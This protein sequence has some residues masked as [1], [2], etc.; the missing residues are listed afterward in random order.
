MV[1]RL[2]RRLAW[3]AA[4]LAAIPAAGGEPAKPAYDPTHDYEV[5]EIEGWRVLVNRKLVRDE[6]L[7]RETLAL[8]AHQLYQIPRKVPA[9]A[10]AKLRKI[11]VWV[12]A[13]EPHHPCMA[14][15]PSADWLREHGMNPEK[16]GCIEVANAKSF[17]DWT[18]QQPW[19]VFHELAHAYHDRFLGGFG[20]REL[21][22]VF[23]RATAARRYERVLHWRGNF[24]RAYAARN[25]MEHFAESSEAFFG[26]NDF[27][28]FVA[29]ELE[30]HDPETFRLLEKLWGR[31]PSPPGDD[32]TKGS[33]GRGASPAP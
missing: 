24:E 26:T 27:Y 25:V 8:L 28:P 7:C 22:A 17:L 32:A 3:I 21:L 20:N 2:C 29:A 14:Y 1:D 16:A 18:R 19:M 30:Q 5:R 10:T 13:N 4:A 15:H 9:E 12:E 33:T 31:R 6:T 23:E 11:S